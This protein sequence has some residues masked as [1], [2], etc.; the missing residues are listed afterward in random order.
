MKN[1]NN[2]KTNI[3]SYVPQNDILPLN[4]KLYDIYNIF[5][6]IHGHKNK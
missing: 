3:I 6:Y 4:F 1:I 2:L 5:K